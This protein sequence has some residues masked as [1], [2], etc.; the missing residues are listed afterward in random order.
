MKSQNCECEFHTPFCP[1]CG[2]RQT[3]AGFGFAQVISEFLSG[4]YNAEAPIVKTFIQMFVAPGRLVREY[5]GGKR[6]AYM[7]PVKYFLFG[8]A[9]YFFMRWMLDWDPVVSAV[10]EE[11]LDTPAMKVNL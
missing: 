1:E 8:A 4:L 6:K 11:V 9:F 3:P 10:G 2:Q 7:S 5:I